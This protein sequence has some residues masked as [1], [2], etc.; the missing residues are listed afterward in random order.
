MPRIDHMRLGVGCIRRLTPI[1][2][3]R[4][5]SVPRLE[6]LSVGSVVCELLSGLYLLARAV[7]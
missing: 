4:G 2:E 5:Q 1:R 6:I 7:S 3:G